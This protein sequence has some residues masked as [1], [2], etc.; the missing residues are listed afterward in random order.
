MRALRGLFCAV[1]LT[2]CLAPG[3]RA[4]EYTKQTFLTFSGPVQLP[5]ITLPAGTY[6]FRLADPESGRRTLQ[7]WDKDGNK[8][9]TT[10]LTIPDQ[11]MTPTNEPVV[12]FG[13]RPS[14][15]PQAIRAWFYPNESYGQEFV[16][17]KDQAMKI[18]RDT[19]TGV[20]SY[21]GEAKDEAAYK[22]AKV[23]RVDENGNMTDAAK[24][25]VTA[26]N[27]AP[28]SSTAQSASTTTAS[29]ASTT[30]ADNDKA[31][32][33]SNSASQT[34]AD[35]S[36]N[37]A[38]PSA[39]RS[40]APAAVGTSGSTVGNSTSEA[41]RDNT[42]VDQRAVGTTGS[43]SNANSANRTAQAAAGANAAAPRANQSSTA[44]SAAPARELPRTASSTMLI[45]LL[46]GLSL[47]GAV[48]LRVFRVRAA[49]SR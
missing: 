24:A 32:T 8:L 13:E 49:A 28:S 20:L 19:H 27:A 31:A 14:G 15:Q 16:Y 44:G 23:G 12:M 25:D 11:R 37:A 42:N 3:A 10:L 2:A 33:A 29:S 9:L 18:A 1:A 22:S 17:P 21:E 45:Q 41:N 7:V 47:A 43:G 36:A 48:A 4:D 35:H 26:A 39:N 30:T 46:A 34:A 5:G 40:A 6:Q 38:M